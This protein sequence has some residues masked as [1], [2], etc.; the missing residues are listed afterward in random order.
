VELNHPGLNPIF[1]T[2]V[3][4]TANYFFSGR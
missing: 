3:A 4:F 2:S 1:D